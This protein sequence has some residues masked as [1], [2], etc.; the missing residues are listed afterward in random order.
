MRRTNHCWFRYASLEP[1]GSRWAASLGSAP[2]DPGLWARSLA[3]ARD[4]RGAA[5]TVSLAARR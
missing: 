5:R 2:H 4:D 1:I 3:F